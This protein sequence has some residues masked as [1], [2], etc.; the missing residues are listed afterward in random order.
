MINQIREV[1]IHNLWGRYNYKWVLNPDVNILAGLNGSGKT[2]LIN[3]IDAVLC[4]DIKR[5]KGYGVD[6][7]IK[8]DGFSFSF[9]KEKSIEG[10]TKINFANISTFDNPLYDRKLYK[11]GESQLDIELDSL[12]YQRRPGTFSFT[13]YRLKATSSPEMAVEINKRIQLFF[14]ILNRLFVGTGKLISISA[15][16]NML[17][18]DSDSDLI[19]LN[20][21]SSG[22]KQLLI[23]L[24][25]VFLMEEIP[26]VL[27]MD[28]PENSL[29]IDWQQQLIDVIRK[30]NPHC[31]IILSTHSPSIFGDGWG[32]K[33]FF[34]EDLQQG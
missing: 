1:E 5:L 16:T 29:H 28:E 6:G 11:K 26:S 24:F 8:G 10:W 2:T 15:V 34:L 23:I 31:Q 32:D 19:E 13:D 7:T 30:L 3:I 17:M 12:I 20:R 27:L 9:D 22:E 4:A 33:L 18:V 25:K 14:D 21:L